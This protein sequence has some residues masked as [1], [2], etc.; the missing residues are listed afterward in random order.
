M[1]EAAMTED[2]SNRLIKLIRRL[3]DG[4]GKVTFTNHNDV[5]ATW[6]H[7]SEIVTPVCIYK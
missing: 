7:A 4:E 6:E 2:L 1:H 3:V 5:H